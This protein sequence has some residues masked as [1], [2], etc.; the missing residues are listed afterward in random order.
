MKLPGLDMNNVQHQNF[1]W[2]LDHYDE[3]F[4]KYGECYVAIKNKRVIGVYTNVGDAVKETNK[5]EVPGT[6]NIQ[7]CNGN[8]SGYTAYYGTLWRLG[9]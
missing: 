8:E 3:I 1:R 4:K 9:E 6:Y 5:T 7:H 2:F